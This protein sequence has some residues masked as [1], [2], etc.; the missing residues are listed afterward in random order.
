MA[1]KLGLAQ[2]YQSG[3]NW[4]IITT[5]LLIYFIIGKTKRSGGGQLQLQEAETLVRF[6]SLARHE[7][8]GNGNILGKNNMAKSP[9]G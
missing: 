5:A 2:L 9:V 1:R 7:I 6:K 8:C 3:S 4:T